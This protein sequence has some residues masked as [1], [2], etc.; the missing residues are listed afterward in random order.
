MVILSISYLSSG[1]LEVL[2]FYWYSCITYNKINSFKTQANKLWNNQFKIVTK[3]FTTVHVETAAGIYILF[4]C[5]DV[6][7]FTLT[8]HIVFDI[9]NG[10]V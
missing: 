2:I 6:L 7:E 9:F 5:L 10:S 8:V 4:S 3:L 1:F